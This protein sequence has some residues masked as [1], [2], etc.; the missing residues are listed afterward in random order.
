VVGIGTSVLFVAASVASIVLTAIFAPPSIPL[1]ALT[2]FCFFPWVQNFISKSISAAAFYKV[3]AERCQDISNIYSGLPKDNIELA[4]Q[5]TAL[6]VN[7]AEM[8]NAEIKA[9]PSLLRPLLAHYTYWHNKAVEWEAKSAKSKEE[10]RTHAEKHPDE[11][12]EVDGIRL[13]SMAEGESHLIAKTH[14]AFYLG[15][16]KNPS[17]SRDQSDTFVFHETI[18]G[19]NIEADLK[20]LGQRALA[21]QFGDTKENKLLSIATS[22]GS[23]EQLTRFEALNM[24]EADIA[25]RLLG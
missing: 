24:S 13:R 1:A 15:L 17:F 3:E 21:T 8:E 19:A 18:D 14:A 20:V 6:G 12:K 2:S 11:L 22:A 23:I 25:Q 9:N 4:H 16:L 10:Q 7:V 5:L